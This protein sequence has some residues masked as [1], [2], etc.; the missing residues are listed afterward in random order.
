MI[1]RAFRIHALGGPQVLQAEELPMPE[2][3]VG[4]VIV[5]VRAARV[6]F[7]EERVRGFSLA[8][9]VTLGVEFASIISKTGESVERLR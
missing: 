3:G 9:P 4:E 8:F 5:A 6:K 7:R 1:D 2:P